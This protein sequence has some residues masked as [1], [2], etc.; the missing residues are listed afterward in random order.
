MSV[1]SSKK[2]PGSRVCSSL[3]KLP[4][5]TI[6][7]RD[8]CLRA[9]YQQCLQNHL[10]RLIKPNPDSRVLASRKVHYS[11][12]QLRS[13]DSLFSKAVLWIMSRKNQLSSS[14]ILRDKWSICE[15]RSMY[16]HLLLLEYLQ[17]LLTTWELSL[18]LSLVF[19]Q[20]LLH[21]NLEEVIQVLYHSSYARTFSPK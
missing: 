21:Q 2:I 16:D 6:S 11:A 20:R 13:I 14:Q 19:H 8:S 5:L 17:H 3:G 15:V 4:Y 10:L 7:C 18:M 9:V 12:Q 1:R